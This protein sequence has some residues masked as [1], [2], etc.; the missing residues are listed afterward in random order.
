MEITQ[1]YMTFSE[2]MTFILA[3]SIRVR[4]YDKEHGCGNKVVVQRL[5]PVKNLMVATLLTNFLR[6]QL[7]TP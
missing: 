3:L 5:Q 2:Y 6:L 1:D 7:K 4:F